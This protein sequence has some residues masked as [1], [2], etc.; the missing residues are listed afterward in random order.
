MTNRK[1]KWG[2]IGLGKIAHKFASDLQ[3]SEKAVLY[4]VA[5]RDISKAKTFAKDYNSIYSYGSYQG[6]AKDPEIDI[7]YI[8]TP[9][10]FHFENTMM[11]LRNG[12]AV[13]CEKPMGMSPN[14]V[15][16]M[17]EEARSRKLF[18]MEGLWTRFIPATDKLMELL[19]A[20]VIGDL[21]SMC[22]DF[23]F[24]GDGNLESRL[25]DKRLGGGSLLDIGIYPIYMSMLTLGLPQDITARAHMTEAGV[26]SFCSMQFHYENGAIAE[27]ESSIESLTPTEAIINGT[28]GNIKLHTRFHHTKKISISH[29]GEEDEVFN[30]PHQGHGY[31]YEIQEANRCLKNQ[32]IESSKLPLNT[33]L[34]LSLLMDR[35]KEKIGLKYESR[36]GIID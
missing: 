27:L 32:K 35:V 28:K 17:V 9:H 2:I 18:L 4:G 22:A 19:N 15:R 21:V 10:V 20:E 14:E 29:R 1:I 31:L 8:A 16:M 11:C 24:K 26:D 7:V 30:I 13:L 25:Y 6:L 33:S 12:K 23:G 34:D 36:V 3:L 5:S